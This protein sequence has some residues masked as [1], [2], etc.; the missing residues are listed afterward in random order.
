MVL[1][2]PGLKALRSAACAAATLAVL[3]FG[4]WASEAGAQDEPDSSAAGNPPAP[5]FASIERAWVVG[6]ADAVL[7][8][9]GKRKVFISLPEG[10]PD[11]GTYS[12]AQS[13]FIL[14]ELF[15]ATRTEEFSFVSIRQPEEQ[16]QTAVGRAERTFRFRDSSR[17]QRDRIFVSLVREGDRWVIAEIKSVR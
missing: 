16:P 6:S 13:Y 12:R 11:G 8:H 2:R 9:F 3:G 15:D 4:A 14:K 1:F 5:T 10:G 7:E 17:T